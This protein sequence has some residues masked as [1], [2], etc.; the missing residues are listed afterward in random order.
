MTRL[1]TL[2][3][4]AAT[5]LSLTA[6][7]PTASNPP[8][9]EVTPAVHNPYARPAWVD[10]PRLAGERVGLGSAKQH[11]QGYNAQRQLAVSRALD[12]LARQQG[13]EIN[14][15]LV[16]QSKGSAMGT[17]S[18]LHTS[19]EQKV[20]GAQVTARIAEEWNSGGELF[21]LMVAD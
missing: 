4:A 3:I 13:V 8:A 12:E 18:S 19:S 21:I 14:N 5:C 9:A 17:S 15:I 1:T 11:M 6:C 7:I 20:S 16:T 10:N 2:F